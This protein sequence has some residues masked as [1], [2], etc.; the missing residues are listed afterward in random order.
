MWSMSNMEVECYVLHHFQWLMCSHNRAVKS[1]TG[2]LYIIC[3]LSV[4]VVLFINYLAGLC[5]HNFDFTGDM[6]SL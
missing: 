3:T 1:K 4:C 2:D 6:H 5:Q